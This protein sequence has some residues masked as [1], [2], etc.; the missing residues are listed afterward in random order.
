MLHLLLL[1][2]SGLQEHR[3]LLVV[4]AEWQCPGLTQLLLR[5]VELPVADVA[6]LVFQLLPA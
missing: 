5:V 4:Q 6:A 3:L 2:Y 1:M